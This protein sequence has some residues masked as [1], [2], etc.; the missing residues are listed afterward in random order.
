MNK[1]FYSIHRQ[2]ETKTK[3][4]GFLHLFLRKAN[5]W[6]AP[7]CWGS[8]WK[9][10]NTYEAKQVKTDWENN[11]PSPRTQEVRQVGLETTQ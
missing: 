10:A 5:E 7:G 2:E 9:S 3:A 6:L 1:D 4:T 11:S 8:E